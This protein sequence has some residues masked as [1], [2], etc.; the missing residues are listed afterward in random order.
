M[1]EALFRKAV[2]GRQDY[3]VRSAGVSAS[4]GAVCSR[5]TKEIVELLKAPLDDFKSQPVT[6]ALLE[7]ATHVFTMTR[8]HLHA[9][10]DHFPEFSE[11]YYMTCEFVDVD[12][13]GLGADV[14][15]PIGMGKKSY[16]EVAKVLNVAIPAIISYIDQT[17]PREA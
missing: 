13:R 5:E 9:L 15:D 4:K 2:A 12:G 7:E 10:E 3:S 11:K 1:A 8:S 17:T 6:A 14:P 16:Q